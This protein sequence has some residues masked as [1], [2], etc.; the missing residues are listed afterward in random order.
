MSVCY[1]FLNLLQDCDS[2]QAN[3]QINEKGQISTPYISKTDR[4]IDFDEIQTLELSPRGSC[5]PGSYFSTTSLLK[6]SK[7]G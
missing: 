2:V 4:L 5:F 3:G 7:I 6:I 1:Y